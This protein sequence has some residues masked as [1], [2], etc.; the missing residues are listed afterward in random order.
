MWTAP[1]QL[2]LL[3]AV[4]RPDVYAAVGL[5]MALVD[6]FNHVKTVLAAIRGRNGS[7]AHALSLLGP[8]SALVRPCRRGTHIRR[9]AASYYSLRSYKPQTLTCVRSCRT[10]S[11]G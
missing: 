3:G 8:Y 6:G 7:V 11:L 4:R 9:A 5:G 10:R 1:L 2:P